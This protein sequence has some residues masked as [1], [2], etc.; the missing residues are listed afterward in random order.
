MPPK[1]LSELELVRLKLF[2]RLLEI[3]SLSLFKGYPTS[4]IAIIQALLYLESGFLESVS[5]KSLIKLPSYNFERLFGDFSG[6]V[7]VA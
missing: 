7:K 3:V 4:L 5:F 1:Y 6:P 2:G